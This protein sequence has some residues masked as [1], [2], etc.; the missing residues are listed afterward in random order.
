MKRKKQKKKKQEIRKLIMKYDEI[1]GI[2]PI[3]EN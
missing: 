3:F 1:F 2:Y